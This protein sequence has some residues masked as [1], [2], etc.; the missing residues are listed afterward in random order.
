MTAVHLPQSLET[1]LTAITQKTGQSADFFIVEALKRYLEDF[2]DRY[3]LEQAI[4]D[5][6][7]SNQKTYTLNQV[8]K[9]LEL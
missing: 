9:E 5:F 1:E 8:E 6:Y 3:E 4:A 2:S 7:N